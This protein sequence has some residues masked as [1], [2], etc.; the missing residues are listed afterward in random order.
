MTKP[1]LKPK[2]PGKP[3]KKGQSGNPKGRPKGSPELRD[4]AR[5]FTAEAIERLA[6]WMRS[7][8]AKASVA[9]ANSLLDRGWGKPIQALSDPDGK[10][11]SAP[12]LNVSYGAS[13][14]ASAPQ[15]G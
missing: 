10:P 11:L 3:F 9:A 14:P 12:I 6:H 15:A 7:D 8:N 5:E 1:K 13:Q 4:L 2:A